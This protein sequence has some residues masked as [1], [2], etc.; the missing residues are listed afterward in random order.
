MSSAAAQDLGV[1]VKSV[2]KWRHK[3]AADWLAGLEDA[4]PIGRPKTGLVLEKAERAR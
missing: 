2:S 3:F 4:A 1:A